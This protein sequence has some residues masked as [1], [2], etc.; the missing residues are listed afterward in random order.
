MDLTLCS[1]KVLKVE[2]LGINGRRF[3][4]YSQDTEIIK[5]ILFDLGPK[6][7]AFGTKVEDLGRE[8]SSFWGK[9][10]DLGKPVQSGSEDTDSIT[11]RRAGKDRAKETVEDLGFFGDP[12]WSK[13]F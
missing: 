3:G 9:V 4:A 8:R 2:D 12:E 13:K 11:R 10:E 5:S 7:R 6:G 1:Y